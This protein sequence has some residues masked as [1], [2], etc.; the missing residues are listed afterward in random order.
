MIHCVGEILLDCF[1]SEGEKSLS[2]ECHLGGAPFNVAA[3]IAS[4]GG[5]ASFYG[6]LGEDPFGDFARKEA[7]RYG[8]KT[9][10]ESRKT[11]TTLALV[12]LREGERS[13]SFLRS[14]GA[15][16]EL[17]A[18]SFLSFAKPKA[19]DVVHF[20]SLLLSKPEGRKFLE[21]A[22]RT[23]FEKGPLLSFDVN[24]R[25]DLF[26]SK[27]EALSFYWRF[28]PSFDVVKMSEDELAYFG[29]ED[30]LAFMNGFLKEGAHLFLTYGKKG[31][32][33]YHRGQKA[34][35]PALPVDPIDTTG[36]GDA[37]YSRVLLELDRRGGLESLK[38]EEIE[39]ILEKGNE[40]GR[41]A[42]LHKGALP[43]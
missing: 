39:G 17:D 7:R 4:Y 10:L 34:F 31:S 20:G 11:N 43:F 30:P 33:Y 6:A 14:P 38:K 29:F 32:A 15:D 19:G 22:L 36:A 27:E 28:L 5:E 18:S 13:F 41:L 1:A 21:D 2:M 16:Y 24:L 3:D 26:A 35:V 42:L 37:F 25:A 12:T 8:V 9:L 40:A 23:L